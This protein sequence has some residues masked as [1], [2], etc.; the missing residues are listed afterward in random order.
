MKPIKRALAL[1]LSISVVLLSLGN[2]QAAI[3]SSQQII[4]HASDLDTKQ[5]LLQTLQRDDIQQQLATMGVSPDDLEQRV[6]HMTPQEMAQLNQQMAQLPAGSSALGTLLFVF[7]I[8][9][10]TDVIGATDIFP[11]IHPVR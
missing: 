10:I 1:I 3:V 6:N 4:Y 5:A 8:F 7:I 11:F 2:A 9:V